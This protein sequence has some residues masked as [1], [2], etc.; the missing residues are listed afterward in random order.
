MVKGMDVHL[1]NPELQAKIDSWISETGRRPDERVEDAVAG[2][3]AELAARRV[4]EAP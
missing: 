1:N 3:F 2:Y 4:G